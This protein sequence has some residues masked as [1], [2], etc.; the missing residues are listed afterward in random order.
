MTFKEFIIQKLQL[1]FFL[2]TMIFFAQMVLGNAIEPQKVFYYSDLKATFII[3]GICILPTLVTCSKKELTFK[4]ML[5]REVI[6]FIIVE[7]IMLTLAIVEIESSPQKIIS[8][9]AIAVATA[10]I[11]NLAILIE[12]YRQYIES[13]K[14]TELL[15]D[16]Q[17]N[18]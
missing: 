15:K 18:Q 9:V 3:A 10:I 1:Y 11:Y 5:V 12:W 6:Q 13:K 2:V 14:M 4:G 7:V 17:K 16:F 8:V